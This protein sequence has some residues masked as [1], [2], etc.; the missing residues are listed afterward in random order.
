MFILCGGNCHRPGKSVFKVRLYLASSYHLYISI[1]TAIG[2]Y[3]GVSFTVV[4][5]ARFYLV[6]NDVKI[7]IHTEFADGSQ[8]STPSPA[9]CIF[10]C[11]GQLSV[12][13]RC[14]MSVP[15]T[16]VGILGVEMGVKKRNCEPRFES[17]FLNTHISVHVCGKAI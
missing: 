10:E 13:V 4:V 1:N 14:D 11:L 17:L 16:I 9:T 7:K 8:N 6:Y 12:Q 15:V 5:I 2:T 3:D